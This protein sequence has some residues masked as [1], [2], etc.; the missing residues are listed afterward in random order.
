MK[1]TVSL[2]F[3]L[4]VIVPCARAAV[5]AVGE[6]LIAAE[7]HFTKEGSGSVTHEGGGWYRFDPPAEPLV[8]ATLSLDMS[9]ARFRAFNQVFV[10]VSN[11]NE[12]TYVKAT[13]DTALP[14]WSSDVSSSFT[15]PQGVSTHEIHFPGVGAPA[16]LRDFR[17][18][19]EH[20]S[21]DHPDSSAAL[22]IRVRVQMRL[23]DYN[24]DSTL[25]N[26]LEANL[27]R[28]LPDGLSAAA[29][30]AAGAK[31][32]ELAARR[33]A[34]RATA[35][36][37]RSSNADKLAAYEELF[38]MRDSVA[39]EIE[40]AALDTDAAAAEASGT[41]LHGV[42]AGAEKIARDGPF[43]GR[44]GVAASVSAARG[45]AEGVQIALYP[46]AALRGV[47]A[48]VSPLVSAG[49]ARLDSAAVTVAPVGYVRPTFP[50]YIPSADFRDTIADPIL[51]W[52]DALDL[53]AGRFQPWWVEA[54]VPTRAVPGV[55]SGTV[56]FAD[57][58]GHRVAVPLSVKVRRVALP[59]HRTL[60]VVFSSNVFTASSALQ[61]V[62]ERDA[63]VLRELEAFLRSEDPDPA[64]LS[65]GARAAWERTLREYRLLVSHNL[66]Y[67]NI[68]CSPSVVQPSWIRAMRLADC[69][70]I[71]TIGYD[72]VSPSADVVG[73]H[74][75]A[76]GDA[77]AS[78]WFYGYD[79]VSSASAYASMKRSFGSVKAAHPQ[80]TTFCT[81]LDGTFGRTSDCLEEV[82]V[83]VDPEDR[84]AG[85]GHQANA[86]EARARGKQVWFYPC[87]WPVIPWA[88][89]HLENTAVANRIVTGAA[90]W[91][92]MTDGVLYYS[93]DSPTPY[94]DTPIISG[95]FDTFSAGAE[96]T[97]LGNC[98]W[99]R[100][101]T[102]TTTSTT[103]SAKAE[104]WESFANDV[105]R[106]P[107]L[108]VRGQVWVDSFRK[109][110]GWGCHAELRFN[111]ADKSLGTNGQEQNYVDVDVSRTRQWQ[112]VDAT[113][114]PKGEVVS[115]LFR[116]Y[117]KSS[118]A[119]VVFRDMR[120]EYA[121]GRTVNRKLGATAPLPRGTAVFDGACYGSFRSNGDGCLVYPGPDGPSAS[122]RLKCVRDG[123][124]DWEYLHTLSNAVLA[125]RSGGIV[126]AS[127]SSAWLAR[128]SAALAI[129]SEVCQSFTSYAANGATL[130]AWRDEMGD[131]LDECEAAQGL[132]ATDTVDWFDSFER[133]SGASGASLA[134]FAGD[135]GHGKWSAS[136]SVVLRGGGAFHGGS[137]LRIADND[138]QQHNATFDL[139]SS[140]S[141]PIPVEDG[142]GTSG[143][144]FS[145]AFRRT[146]VEG[147]TASLTGCKLKIG[148]YCAASN[149][150]A[151][152]SDG[153]DICSAPAAAKAVVSR[154]GIWL[155]F[156]GRIVRTPLSGGKTRFGIRA[157]RIRSASGTTLWRADAG[158]SPW[159]IHCDTA[160]PGDGLRFR[161]LTFFTYSSGQGWIDLDSIR[162]GPEPEPT[163]LLMLR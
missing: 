146:A 142:S 162:F 49:G 77:S 97:R 116:V 19:V 47:T 156:E 121:D 75:E 79:E 62:Y 90:S 18:A 55:Y 32:S 3:L 153:G 69:P 76:M 12:S 93:V 4:A 63:A 51:E 36:S 109:S 124:D 25:W 80:V 1:R 61:V 103:S 82:D 137:L 120:V 155:R 163:T 135:D 38:A 107:P 108:R 59:R 84:F 115:C 99:N 54:S 81:A 40:K 70:S 60:P 37:S 73:A 134:G 157:D 111:Y 104:R 92:K 83:W 96:K 98:G 15:A 13:L 27:S 26:S 114:V 151:N 136:G 91:K 100:D 23:T 131:L 35:R 7:A 68:Y 8:T 2:L 44:L 119:R 94:A 52:A 6:P 159:L 17:L 34:L 24:I 141:F 158:A 122:L 133:F 128:A 66:P 102:L 41:L 67:Q 20:A 148:A 86:A 127:G 129:P 64:A 30:A 57:D 123:I 74:V 65:D 161:R 42:A 9:A 152:S 132:D 50:A 95:G 117:A 21:S 78:I 113:I 29:S 112:D 43:A 48:S 138:A 53:E 87:N 143:V 130:D 46:S 16:V 118:G 125:V 28:A 71:F 160:L 56:T 106:L 31:R 140:A 88:N 85:S 110:S 150:W 139:L 11:A 39:R 149:A 72:K 58:A 154:T 126:P 89:L 147:S 101:I 5:L 14:Q 10:T 105:D 145:F 22:P 144:P 45:E 33:T